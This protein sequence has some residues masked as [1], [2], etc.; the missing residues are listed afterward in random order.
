MAYIFGLI[1]V[2]LFFVVLHYFTEL[3]KSQ[4]LSITAIILVIILSAIT[5]NSYN[6]AQSQKLLEVVKKFEQNK[7]L[8]CD[9]KEV[10]STNYDLSTGTYTFIGR[11]NSPYQGEMISATRCE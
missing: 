5:Y 11:K 6:T 10:N 4:K 3:T 7:T 8:L 1:I 9:S 2:T